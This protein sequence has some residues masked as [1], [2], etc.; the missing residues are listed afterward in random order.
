MTNQYDNVYINETATIV[1][2]YEK[3]GPLNHTLIKGMM[4]YI[5]DPIPGNRQ[6]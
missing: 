1:G 6:K 5:L 4:I 3:K 2:P